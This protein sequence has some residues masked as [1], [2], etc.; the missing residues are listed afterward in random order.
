MKEQLQ[1]TERSHKGKRLETG[2]G[3]LLR[4]ECPGWETLKLDS[5]AAAEAHSWP[6]GLT[7]EGA[8]REPTGSRRQGGSPYFLP[9]PCRPLQHPL[10]A[11]PSMATAGKAEV[12]LRVPALM[13]SDAASERRM[14]KGGFKVET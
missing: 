13:L 5:T 3:A 12:G 8:E 11:K 1:H 14:Q 10:L 2:G 9:Q 4:W 6:G 7:G